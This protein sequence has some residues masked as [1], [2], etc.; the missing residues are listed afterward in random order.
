MQKEVYQLI[1]NTQEHDRDSMEKMLEK[2]AP[3]LRWASYHL[4]RE[5][6]Y[7][8]FSAW[9]LEMLFSVDLLRLR[10][11]SDAGLVTYIK[12]AVHHQLIAFRKEDHKRVCTSSIEDLSNFDAERFERINS[13][14]DFYCD[15]FL[16]DLKSHLTGLE[17]RV[18]FSVYVEGKKP[19]E[20]AKELQVSRQAVNE[21]KLN[22]L[23]KL[24][25]F[26]Q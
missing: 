8:D 22:A 6:A 19:A 17:Y 10:N 26:I 25:R 24:K 3:L 13:T 9:F 11:T 15:L 12:N 16:Q 5:D 1:R 18:I 4:N 20:L 21:V 2:F 7:E 23:R 14:N